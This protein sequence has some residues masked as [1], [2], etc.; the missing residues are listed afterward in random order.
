MRNFAPWA[1]IACLAAVPAAA[2][3][4]SGVYLSLAGGKADLSETVDKLGLDGLGIDVQFD[5]DSPAWSASGGYQ[6]NR[7]FGARVGYVDFQTF[8]DFLDAGPAGMPDVELDLEGWQVGLDAWVPVADWASLSVHAG[9]MDWRSNI[10]IGDLGLEE[11]DS[12]TDPFFGG[13]MELH[14]GDH[15][16]MNV[17]YTRFDVDGSDVDYAALGV[18]IRF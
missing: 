12:G 14:L 2:D 8:D 5:D 16:G 17:S 11:K 4:Q 15:V 3:D 1:A 10:K 13:G 7:Y 6:V 9:Y 18:R